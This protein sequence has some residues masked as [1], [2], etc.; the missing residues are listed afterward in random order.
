MKD[1]FVVIMAGGK[2]ERFWPQSRAASPKHL[3]PI[4]GE[5]PMLAQTVERLHGFIPPE[6]VIVI[7][8]AEQR[9]MVLRA[10]PEL[11]PESVIGEPMGRDTAAAVGLA[12]VLVEDRCAGATFAMLP[13]D[14]VIHDQEGFQS[15]L[16]SAFAAAEA[17]EYLVTIGIKPDSP[18]TGYGYIHQGDKSDQ[19]A[20]RTVYKVQ[21]FVEKPDLKTAQKYVDSGEYYWN[22]GMFIWTTASIGNAFDKHTPKLAEGLKTIETRLSKGDA[23]ETILSDEYPGLEKISI[24][25]AIMEKAD[26]VLMVESD[27]DWDDVGAW[28]AVVRHFDADADGNVIRGSA[29]IEGGSG[30]LV[31]STPEHLTAVVG[32]QD[33]IVVHTHDATL[34]CPKDKAQEVKA[35]VKR[36]GA[37]EALKHLT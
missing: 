26:N 34:V 9:E 14:H 15:V 25:Y 28:P 23:L 37:E 35:L 20:G 10:C 32:A 18:A 1:R 22:A 36:L 11:N 30:N 12:K 2:G 4:V 3:L 33:L 13:A 21:R 29:M 17:G 8:N 27:F 24:D 5:R 6:R 31:V 19:Q 16:E 7:T